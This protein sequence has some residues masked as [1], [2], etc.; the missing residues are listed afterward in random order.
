MKDIIIYEKAKFWYRDG[1]LFCELFNQDINHNLYE[2]SARKY[3]KAISKLCQGKMSPFV[4]DVRESKGTY[5]NGAA[6]L[7]SGS[8]EL[9]KVRLSEA[10]ILNSMKL[11]LSIVSYKRIYSPEIDYQIFDDMDDAITYSNLKKEAFVNAIKQ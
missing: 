8:P 5:T 9:S 3:I 2:R 11:K 10:F 4:I 1:I 7:I 6:R